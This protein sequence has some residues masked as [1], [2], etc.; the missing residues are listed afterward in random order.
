MQDRKKILIADDHPLMRQGIKSVLASTGEYEITEKGDGESALESLTQKTFDVCILDIEMPKQSGLEVARR[1]GELSIKTKI[2]FLTMYKDEDIFNQSLDIGAMGYVLK[3]NAVND[4][5]DCIIK[6]L[7]NE[8]YIS[9]VISGFLVSRLKNKESMIS[10][11]PG[12]N[13]L[14]ISERKILKL[15]ASEK[16]TQQIADELHISYKTVENHRNNISKKLNLSG[17]HSLVKFAIS[18]K[19]LL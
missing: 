2:I 16:T 7:N 14:T 11:S 3:E 17:T 10:Q 5:V 6:V 1:I 15:I 8:Y 18:N 12:I 19:A 9:P 4:I 13:A